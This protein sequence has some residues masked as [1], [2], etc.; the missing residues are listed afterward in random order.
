MNPS[1]LESFSEAYAPALLAAVVDLGPHLG[2]RSAQQYAFDTALEMIGII[3][4]HGV[5]AVSHYVLNARGGA[6]RHTA[7]TLGIDPTVPAL[8]HYLEE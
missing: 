8:Q 4:S 3:Q 5:E 7:E 2:G 6:F 1:R